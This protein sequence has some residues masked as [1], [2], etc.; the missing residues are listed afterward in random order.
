MF[1]SLVGVFFENSRGVQRCC[2]YAVFEGAYVKKY[3]KSSLVKIEK[4]FEI[5]EAAVYV[6]KMKEYFFL[7]KIVVSRKIEKQRLCD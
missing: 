6:R 7:K 2:M 5:V 3:L 4:A 1:V